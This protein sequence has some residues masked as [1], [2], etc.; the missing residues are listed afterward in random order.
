[1]QVGQNVVQVLEM[2]KNTTGIDLQSLAKKY[3][4]VDAA[5]ALP[6]GASATPKYGSDQ[7]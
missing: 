3:T 7:A 2:L 4:D 1:M 6:D 5:P